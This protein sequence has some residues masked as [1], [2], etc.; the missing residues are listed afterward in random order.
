MESK[1]F[2][3]SRLAVVGNV[4]ACVRLCAWY[5]SVAGKYVSVAYSASAVLY[6]VSK[7]CSII[8]RSRHDAMI[9][10]AS[11]THAVHTQPLHTVVIV[12]DP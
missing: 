3:L 7:R 1:S 5:V 6:C 4:H 2:A 11:S 8:P 10:G 12:S 9:T